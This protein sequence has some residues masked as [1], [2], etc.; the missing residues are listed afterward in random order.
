[1]SEKLVTVIKQGSLDN[2]QHSKEVQIEKN[3]LSKP[4]LALQKVC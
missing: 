2:D 1:M 3:F 4:D